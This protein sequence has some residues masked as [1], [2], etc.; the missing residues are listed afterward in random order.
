[1]AD[2][3][4]HGIMGGSH[5]RCYPI[6]PQFAIS[7]DC[8]PL[9]HKSNYLLRSQRETNGLRSFSTMRLPDWQW[10]H[11]KRLQTNCCRSSQTFRRTLDSPRCDRNC[12]SKS[13]LAQSRLGFPPANLFL[14]TLDQ[15]TNFEHSRKKRLKVE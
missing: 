9:D 2:P 11:R 1:M 7:Y 8:A 14:F 4:S 13:R 3:S 5:S 10:N 12:Q 6:L 15:L